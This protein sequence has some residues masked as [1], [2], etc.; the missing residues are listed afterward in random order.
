MALSLDVAKIALIKL[1]IIKLPKHDK[2]REHIESENYI[3]LIF[4]SVGEEK[5]WEKSYD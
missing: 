4:C 3:I 2:R 1:I 5:A